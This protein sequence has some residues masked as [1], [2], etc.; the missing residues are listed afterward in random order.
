MTETTNERLAAIASS[1]EESLFE[2]LDKQHNKGIHDDEVI[3]FLRG[4]G[5]TV[6]ADRYIEWSGAVDPDREDPSTLGGGVPDPDNPSYAPL[7]AKLQEAENRKAAEALVQVLKDE[8]PEKIL[9]GN[10]WMRYEGD[11]T[12]VQIDGTV[13][14]VELV[15]AARK[16][17][18][19]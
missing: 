6:L 3:R 19:K 10:G 13:N 2:R 9:Y 15:A 16:A 17:M 14:F 4:E 8:D 7:V 11:P 12:D 5:H 18:G 1:F